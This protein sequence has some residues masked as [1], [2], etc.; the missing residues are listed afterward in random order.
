MRSKIPHIDDVKRKAF[1]YHTR[2][3]I[4]QFVPAQY[5]TLRSVQSKTEVMTE[6]ASTLQCARVVRETG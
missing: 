3:R 4:Y 2:E 6:Q 1:H 5:K